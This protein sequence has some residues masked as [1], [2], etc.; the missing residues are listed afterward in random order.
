MLANNINFNYLLSPFSFLYG[1]GVAIR[2]KLFDW[3]ILPSEQFPIPVIC[4]GNLAVGGTGKTPHTEYLIRFLRK[5]YK[6]AVLSRG[7]KRKTK[8]FLLADEHSTSI[9]IGDEPFQMYIKYPDILVAVDAER[10]RGIHNLLALEEKRRPDIILLDD[11]FQHRYVIPS[12][13][14]ILTDYARPFYQ[15]KLLPCGRL[16]EPVTSLPR[17]DVVI[18]TKCEGLK[19]IDYRIIEKN[20]MLTANQML[21]FTSIDYGD[22]K[23]LFPREAD[24]WS[25]LD[26]RW[27]DAV[28]L[29]A[30]IA[31]PELF[32]KKIRQYTQ[33]VESLIYSD[34]H[35][36]TP[37]DLTNIEKKFDAI[38]S[39]GKLIIV[40]EKDAA[41][42]KSYEN[43][44][45]SLRKVMYYLP[46]K[47]K[48]HVRNSE[49]FEEMINKRIALFQREHGSM[50]RY[51]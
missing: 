21:F 18:V 29:V 49:E 34:H 20:I 33:N 3:N 39:L 28:L 16:R 12:F 30:G 15:D 50:R 36:F 45:E 7:Y 43:I 26:I 51:E 31:S 14:I 8:G 24:V 4:V 25:L 6:V 17:A 2:N 10:R 42:L 32:I 1:L 19:P 22:I 23:P 27:K 40:T 5:R 47:V 13:S 11:A 38:K 48:F 46:I 41:R 37:Q 9:S 35:S 44:P